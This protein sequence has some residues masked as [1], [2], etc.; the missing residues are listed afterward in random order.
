MKARAYV[1]ATLLVVLTALGAFGTEPLKIECPDKMD[2]N[3][4]VRVSLVGDADSALW[5]VVPKGNLPADAADIEMK[6]DNRGLVFTGPSGQYAVDCIGGKIVDG[7]L[8]LIRAKKIVTI[9]PEVPLPN[10]P[11]PRPNPT[12]GKR[13]ALAIIE[14]STDRN[15]M[16]AEMQ[17]Q[18]QALGHKWV[19]VDKD[20][21]QADAPSLYPWVA[22]VARA[23]LP[24]PTLLILRDG[25]DGEEPLY[26]GP[27]PKTAAEVIQKLKE[28]GG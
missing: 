6:P 21:G 22:Y 9:G 12:P 19:M 17:K 1:L 18:V 11:Q 28:A 13:F 10:P 16:L 15:L 20:A 14:S 24:K 27:L 3:K 8:Q 2:A 26:R 7:K 25:A 23:N 4:L 5:E